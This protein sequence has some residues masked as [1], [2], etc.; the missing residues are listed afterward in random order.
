MADDLNRPF[1]GYR[2]AGRRPESQQNRRAAA[3]APL[4]ALR[5]MVSGVLGAPGDIESLIRMLPGLSEQTVLPTSEDVEKRLP[6]RELNQTPTGKAFTTAG[7]L[8]GGFYVGPGSPLRAI[9]ALPSAVSRAGRD[10]AMASGQSVSPMVVYHGSPHKFSRFDSSKIGTGEGAQAYGHGLYLAESP[11]VA[12]QYQRNLSGLEVRDKG[13]AVLPIPEDV[14]WVARYLAAAGG[15]YNKARA[16]LSEHGKNY[17]WSA[18][19]GTKYINELEAVG[20]K[21]VDLGSLYK[22]DLPDEKIAKMLDW[23]KGGRETYEDLAKK[24]SNYE[25]LALER[26]ELLNKY[27]SNSMSESVKKMT[28]KDRQRFFEI[29]NLI[30][31]GEKNKYA[32]ASDYFRE[33]GVPGIKYLD[34]ESRN[35]G[36]FSITPPG[37]TVSGKW[38]VKGTDYNSSGMHFD[39][40]AEAI[41][42]LEEMNAGATR[43]FVLFPGEEDA[44]TILKRNDEDLQQVGSEAKSL[45]EMVRKYTAPQ[46]EALMLAQQRAALPVEQGGLGLPTNNTAAERAAA[47]GFDLDTNYIHMT[48]APFDSINKT[49]RFPGVFSLPNESATGYGSTSMPFYL[50]GEPARSRDLQDYTKKTIK[51]VTGSSGKKAT[52][53]IEDA[54]EQ[55]IPEKYWNDPGNMADAFEE[56]QK[57]RMKL[58]AELNFPAVKMADEFNESTV[59]LLPGDG[60]RSRFAAFDPWRKTAATAALYGVAAPDLLASEEEPRARIGLRPDARGMVS[61][62]DFADNFNTAV[63]SAPNAQ[64]YMSLDEMRD[65]L[66]GTLP[67]GFA[68]GG[69]VRGYQAGGVVN[70]AKATAKNIGELVRKYTPETQLNEA[71]QVAEE[72]KKLGPQFLPKIEQTNGGSVYLTVSKSPLTKQGVPSKNRNSTPIDFK[73]RFADHPSYWGSTISSD[74]V[75][76]NTPETIVKMFKHKIGSGDLPAYSEARFNPADKYG[77]VTDIRREEGV[78]HKGNPVMKTIKDE[79]PFTFYEP[80]ARGKGYAEGGQVTGAN[81]PTDD[82]DPARIDAIVGELHALNAG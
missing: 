15:D 16:Q 38:M 65:F 5:G 26:D 24:L 54:I 61:A 55:T 31:A 28:E 27:P 20:A 25:A 53:K 66:G 78:T 57:T 32:L 43:N 67:E 37:E 50:R 39:T 34:Q 71:T 58:A 2:S 45:G 40:E 3:D 18:E 52:Q 13:G 1:I 44:L 56:M 59:A 49:G 22:V 7:Q 47:M 14:Q 36:Q 68:R 48:N 17:P 72:I 30:N 46:D 35:A 63:D 8:G 69:Q 21:P 9:A 76:G 4:S 82:F 29:A 33:Q 11:E 41:A 6:M 62:P 64:R 70:L 73:A 80:G 23:D 77:Y 12:G 51:S 10:F 75:T 81:F 42:K 79:R 60:V 19:V 74:P